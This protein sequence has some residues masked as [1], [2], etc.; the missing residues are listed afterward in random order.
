M[1][2]TAM[3]DPG[4][5]RPRFVRIPFQSGPIDAVKGSMRTIAALP[6]AI[7]T[8]VLALVLAAPA[9]AGVSTTAKLRGDAA[10]EAVAKVGS[11]YHLGSKGPKR[12][13]CSGLVHFAFRRAGKLLDVRTSQELWKLGVKV[14]RAKLRRG[15]LVFTWDR[16]KGHVGIY[17]GG[18][19]YVH[20]P[21]KGRKVEVAPLPKLRAGYYGA[22]RI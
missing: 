16:R 2:P 12:F 13:D 22:V 8:L 9:Q 1:K 6:V 3:R 21:G 20:A 19:R 18:G 14:K 4:H 7:A 17:L 11:P 5:A 15:D 10:S